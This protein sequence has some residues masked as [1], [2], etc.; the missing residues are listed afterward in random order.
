MPGSIMQPAGGL[1]GDPAASS[2]G[3]SLVV[4]SQLH[5]DHAHALLQTS[6]GLSRHVPGSKTKNSRTSNRMNKTEKATSLGA[7]DR[8]RTA[9][10]NGGMFND[11]NSGIKTYVAAL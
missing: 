3:N 5:P 10:Q 1:V 8:V 9:G 11:N 7:R 4:H 2:A 6:L